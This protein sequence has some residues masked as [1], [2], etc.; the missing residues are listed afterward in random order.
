MNKNELVKSVSLTFNRI[1]FQLQKKSPEIL[2]AVGV[3]G[4]VASAVM[5]CKATPKACKVA[6]KNAQQLDTIHTADEN[7][8][9]NAGEVYT[10]ED[11]RRDT[12]Q[13]Y[14]QTG[15]SYV[16]LYAP[17]VLLGAASITCIL[18]SHH[19]LKKRN[20]ALAAAYTALDR[21]FKDYRDRVLDRFGEQVEKELRYNTGYLPHQTDANGMETERSSFCRAKGAESGFRLGEYHH[22]DW[23]YHGR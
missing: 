10:K 18:S 21:N 23:W 7:G 11:V 15:I 3:V 13:V 1:G 8:V 12:I 6:E 9:T 20:V 2:V 4:V 22:A 5:A 19:I 17:A 14:T 16:K